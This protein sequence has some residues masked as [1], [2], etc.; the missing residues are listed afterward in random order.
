MWVDI[1]VLVLLGIFALLGYARGLFSQAWSLA[2]LVAA[3]VGAQPAFDALAPR[4]GWRDS[5]SFLGDWVL[6]VVLGVVLYVL[7]LILG[8]ILEK[9]LIDRFK[10]LS[11][12]NRIFGAVL[13]LIKGAIAVVVALWV[14]TF[15]AHLAPPRETPWRTQIH[16]SVSARLAGRYNPLNLFLLARVKP[17]LPKEATGRERSPVKPPEAVAKRSSFQALLADQAFLEA[18]RKRDYLDILLNPAFQRMVTDYTLLNAL[19]KSQH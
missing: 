7:L 6:K 1:G 16:T 13:G 2:A 5:D 15:L 19:E 14:A 18:Y 17:Y 4:F 12:G 11:A 3:F 10:L 9:R 8:Y